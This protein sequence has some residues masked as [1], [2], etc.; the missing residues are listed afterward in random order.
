MAHGMIEPRKPGKP[1][2]PQEAEQ[3]ARR[4]Q[5]AQY[6]PEEWETLKKIKLA[7]AQC[8]RARVAVEFQV[9][10]RTLKPPGTN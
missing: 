7:E 2:N 3:A 9:V 6:T 8:R 4:S 1:R 10:M 5:A